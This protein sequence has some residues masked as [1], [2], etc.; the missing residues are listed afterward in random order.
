MAEQ[1]TIAIMAGGE[2]RRMGRDK[3]LLPAEG[4][5]LLE[6]VARTAAATGLPV[7]VVGRTPPE[8]WSL[9]AIKFYG[10]H[11][12]GLGP[13]GGIATALEATTT[14]ILALP[15]DLPLLTTPAI[16]WLID[17]ISGRTLDD[18]LVTENGSQLEP[19]FSIYRRKTLP[20]LQ[21]RLAAKR[22]S[23]LGFL[24]SAKF[25]YI[26]APPEVSIALRNANTPEEW[27][28]ITKGM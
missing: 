17:G 20:A 19:L 7:I 25:E 23:I 16:T 21:S 11:Y 10:D 9:S 18:G 1:I 14:D 6:Y 28:Q 2:S 4:G 15:C 13:L 26:T 22:L 24:M 12:P 5:I 27:Q 8:G 3:A